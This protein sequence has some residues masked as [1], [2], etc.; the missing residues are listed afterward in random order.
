MGYLVS[1]L[2]FFISIM[3]ILGMQMFTR[4]LWQRCRTTPEPYF[5]IFLNQTVWPIDPLQSRLCGGIYE[6]NPGTYCGKLLD[7]NLPLEQDNVET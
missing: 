7:Y 2:L 3:A 5:D 1:F 6:C 4:N